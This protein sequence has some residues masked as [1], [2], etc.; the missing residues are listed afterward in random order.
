MYNN[1]SNNKDDD[2]KNKKS[3]LLAILFSIK[4]LKEKKVLKNNVT[5]IVEQLIRP[6]GI[7]DPEIIIRPA[8]GEVVDLIKEI[9][10]RS[11]KKEKVLDI[12]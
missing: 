12:G 6:T 7:I 5:G 10:I 1:N 4:S 11:K 8:K 9:E 2:N 3:G